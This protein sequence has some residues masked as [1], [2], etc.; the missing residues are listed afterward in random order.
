MFS[1]EDENHF[2]EADTQPTHVGT[3]YSNIL[4]TKSNSE[5]MDIFLCQDGVGQCS[6]YITAVQDQ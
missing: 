4:L 3:F 5:S 1:Q 6:L 2:A